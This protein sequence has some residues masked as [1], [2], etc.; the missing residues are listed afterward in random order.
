MS[1]QL[2]NL[3][4]STIW[5]F[6]EFLKYY[7]SVSISIDHYAIVFTFRYIEFTQYID[8][9]F[10]RRFRFSVFRRTP[11]LRKYSTA[12]YNIRNEKLKKKERYLTIVITRWRKG[13]R[14][15]WAG[16]LLKRGLLFRR[17]KPI[18]WIRNRSY[19]KRSNVRASQDI[20]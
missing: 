16:K 15:G 19:R 12:E 14:G 7:I 20:T 9:L 2:K 5:V 18:P 3:T 1:K 6:V 8:T 4:S 11:K 17:D 13:I 10:D